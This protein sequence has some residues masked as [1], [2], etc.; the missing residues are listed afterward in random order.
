VTVG[1]QTGPTENDIVIVT[2]QYQAR[3][4]LFPMHDF[5]QCPCDPGEMGIVTTLI[6]QGRS[7]RPQGSATQLGVG[8]QNLNPDMLFPGSVP[9]LPCTL[10]PGTLWDLPP[11]FD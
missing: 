10:P 4:Q 8:S 7:S 3:Y 5:F 11:H 6:S 2:E 1:K 9:C